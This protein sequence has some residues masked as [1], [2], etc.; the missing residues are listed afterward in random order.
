MD[1]D[2]LK[3]EEDKCTQENP[4]TCIA[5]CPI[6]VDARKLMQDIQKQDLKS[7][8]V[9]LQKKQPFPGIIG[10]ICDHPCED[11]CKRREVGSPIA[12]S[13]LERFCVQNQAAK[14]KIMKVPPK[15][16]TVAV[17]GSGLKRSDCS[18]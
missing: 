17:V 16:Q 12:I 15:S 13:A 4:P 10:R 3:R 2:E 5:G 14:T 11:V 7:A 18:L 8:L 9:T 6:H 1:Q